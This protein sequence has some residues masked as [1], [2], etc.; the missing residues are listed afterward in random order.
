MND[1]FQSKINEIK[2]KADIVDIISE[3]IHLEKQGANYIGICPFHED[4]NPSLT[5]SPT[6]K[7]FKCF[8]C[9]ASGN[10]ISFVEKF[11]K[12]PF[13][14][15]LREVGAKVGVKI[16]PTNSEIEFQ[17][18]KKYYDIMAEVCDF[19][20]FYL[21]NTI[22]GQTALQYLEKR[23]LDA[24][25]IERFKIG[26]SGNEPDLLYRMLSEKGYLPIDMVEVGLIKSG[27]EYYDTFR[28]RIMFPITDFNGFF[29]GFSGR[30]YLPDSDEAKY[31]N[32]NENIIFKKGQILYNFHEAFN[33]IKKADAVFVFE[34]FMD[35]IAAY[36]AGVLNAVATM[37][38]ALT[39]NQ[40]KAI[41]RVTSN[42]ILCYDGDN[43]GIEAT[44]RA[45][46]MF[47]DQEVNTRVVL[48]PDGLDPD[49]YLD[50]HGRAALNDY[51]LKNNLTAI[52]YIYQVAKRDLIVE[53][54]NSLEKF[55]NEV[56]EYLCLYNSSLIIE[57]ILK[58]L[59]IDLKVSLEGLQAEFLV[60]KQI[61]PRPYI[62][63]DP[64][65]PKYK[66]RHNK[67]SKYDRIQKQL[68]YIALTNPELIE[69]IENRFNNNYVNNSNRDIMLK[70]HQYYTTNKTLDNEVIK[71]KLPSETAIVFEQI[72][73]MEFPPS[74]KEV[75]MLLDDFNNFPNEKQITMLLDEKKDVESLKEITMRK[76]ATTKLKFE[77]SD[78]ND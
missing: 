40:I 25:I 32:S 38:T 48:M 55:K 43:P 36:K 21:K 10:A 58:N 44:K 52:E 62:P 39:V 66:K 20:H 63:V 60:Q 5:V 42:V 23:K 7:I 71:S 35:V 74:V 2:E 12:I 41:K 33:D 73:N 28:R 59:S 1:N 64:E 67:L 30:K 9:N 69:E 26:L 17:R 4:K 19:Y 31:I 13:M 54:L 18:H 46:Q 53:D 56:F 45:I 6:K 8:S 76:K 75:E 22:E 24:T 61:A 11:K 47:F 77:R 3:H 27:N 68:I 15:A 49:E 37:G 29:V 78:S 72:L 16:A 34:G 14:E 70:I 50:K 51:L 57:K 65:K